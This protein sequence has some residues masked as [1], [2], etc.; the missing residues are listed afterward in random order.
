[1]LP[2]GEMGVHFAEVLR[3]GALQQLVYHA[4]GV[5]TICIQASREEAAPI[6]R[7]DVQNLRQAIL[8]LLASWAASRLS[9]ACLLQSMAC[10]HSSSGL[11]M[12]PGSPARWALQ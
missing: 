4:V 2:V 1:M 9:A 6:L 7:Q 10:Q 11:C 5:P 12:L 8:Q 3:Q